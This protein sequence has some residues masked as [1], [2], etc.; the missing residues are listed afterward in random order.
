MGAEADA[1]EHPALAVAAGLAVVSVQVVGAK[2]GIGVGHRL[3][4]GWLT[5]V[6]PGEMVGGEGGHKGQ[7]PALSMGL[8]EMGR[9]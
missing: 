9:E 2:Q 1:L 6:S 8:D 4:S 5:G 7:R 3:S